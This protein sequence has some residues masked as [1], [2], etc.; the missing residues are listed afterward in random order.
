MT[1]KK[2]VYVPMA[3]DTIH[4]GHLN[5]INIAA[6]LGRVVVGLF[7]DEA[8]STY[9]KTPAMNFEMR[10]IVVLGLKG[11]D[12]VIP[13]LSRDYEPNLRLLK[14][15]YMVH[16]TDWREGPLS[17]VRKRAIDVMAEWSGEIV[18]PEYTKGVSSSELKRIKQI[19][20]LS[21]EEKRK[22]LG[23]ELRLKERIYGITVYDPFSVRIAEALKK[24]SLLWVDYNEISEIYGTFSHKPDLSEYLNLIET[25]VKMSNKPLVAEDISGD[26]IDDFIYSLTEFQRRG[27][28]GICIEVKDLETLQNK[29][30][31][32]TAHL[33]ESLRLF[34]YLPK[35]DDEI[36][37]VLKEKY[38]ELTSAIIVDFGVSDFKVFRFIDGDSK[39]EFSRGIYKTIS[40]KVEMK[41][42]EE[43]E[44]L[45]E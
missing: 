11:V 21:P 17:E 12:E 2:T 18:E 4:P 34:F 9:K 29:M 31:K 7:T 32:Y 38:E 20:G 15:D 26:N 44:G 1:D 39:G 10:K 23:D 5:I 37:S 13:Q 27:L 30:E 8:I 19:N 45:L 41:V 24:I 16:G 25:L 3:A 22:L 36:I 28:S 14:P 42:R 40:Q 6:S 43:I 33:N 35:A